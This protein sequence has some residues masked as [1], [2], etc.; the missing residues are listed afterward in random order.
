MKHRSAFSIILVVFLC[1]FSASVRAETFY[2]YLEG[3]QEAP[4]PVATTAKG[5][6]RVFVNPTTLAYSF[7]CVFTGLTSAQNNAHIHAPAPIG[8]STG[9][10]INF[11][12]VGGTSGTITGSGTMTAG[13]LAQIRA[14]QAYVNVHSVNFPGGEIRG[15]L[16]IKRPVDFDGD[17]RQD[18]SVLRFPNIASPGI[19]PIRYWTRNSTAGPSVSTE[20]GNANTDFPTPGDFD[21][22]GKDDLALFRTPTP[23]AP[24]TEFW[25]LRSSDGTSQ[26]ILFGVAGD[27]PVCRDFDGDGITDVAIFRRGAAAGDVTVWWIRRSTVGLGVIGSD[28]VIPFG[29]S[30]NGSTT[31]DVPIPGDYDGDGKFDFAVYRVG[32]AP[33]N[34]Y[35]ILN[36]SNNVVTWRTFGSFNTDWIVPGDYDGDGRFD[37]A[38]ARGFAG[39]N[40]DW[41]FILSNGDITRGPIHFGITSDVPT[42]GDYDGDAR[43]DIAVYRQGT[44]G[45]GQS[46]SWVMNSF[47]NTTSQIPW[48]ANMGGGSDFPVA[49]FDA[50]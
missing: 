18:V 44:A 15:Q 1:G 46:N 43:T 5:Y 33:A 3:R 45:G 23:G 9:V 27:T 34:T 2:A 17:G 32:Q 24:Q 6:A 37:L 13:Q 14:H 35:I 50:R 4:T 25:I 12:V 22:D 30:G 10:A 39:P 21:G 40:M 28:L 19:A 47:D 7:T 16:G 29:L 20:F 11:G 49:S 41:W 26:Q 36:S 8:T 48:G 38:V 31:F 42:Q